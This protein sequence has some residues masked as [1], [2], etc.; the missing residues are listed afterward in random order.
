[1]GRFVWP[2]VEYILRTM[3]PNC[4]WVRSLDVAVR[5]IAKKAFRLP[6]RTI[7]S[8]PM[9]AWGIGLPNVENDLDIVWASQVYKFLASKDPKEVIICARR[10]RD[11]VAARKAVKGASF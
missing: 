8:F 10:L 3:L 9:E 6:Q 1:M 4:T 7:T 2:K 5:G 11:T